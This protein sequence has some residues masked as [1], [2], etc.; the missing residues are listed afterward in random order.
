MAPELYEIEEFDGKLAD[1]F[2]SAVVL[3]KMFFGFMPF[4]TT[5]YRTYDKNAPMIMNGKWDDFWSSVKNHDGRT[6]VP[7]PSDDLKQL[8]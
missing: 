6:D 1:Y 5:D 2:A 4:Y 7:T 8:F 3:F